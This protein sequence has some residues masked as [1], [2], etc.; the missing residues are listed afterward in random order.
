M[1]I[2]KYPKN[3]LGG[4]DATAAGGGRREQSEWPWSARDD[5]VYTEDIAGYHNRRY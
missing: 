3:R 2:R 1:P 5:G 4:S